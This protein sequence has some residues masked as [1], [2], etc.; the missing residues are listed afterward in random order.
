MNPNTMNGG[1]RQSISGNRHLLALPFSQLKL[2]Q[3]Q[4][5]QRVVLLP[6]AS[7]IID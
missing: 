4:L 5:D 1:I 7:G 2:V 3:K 6:A